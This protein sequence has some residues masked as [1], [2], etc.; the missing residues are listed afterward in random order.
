MPAISSPRW[1]LFKSSL[2][3]LALNLTNYIDY[4]S[5]KSEMM[6]VVHHSSVPMRS[7]GDGSSSCVRSLASH[8]ARKLHLIARYEKL[9]QLLSEKQEYDPVHVNDFAPLKPQLC[10]IYI[11]ELALPFNC[12]LYSYSYGNNLGTLWFIWKVPSDKSTHQT[13]ILMEEIEKYFILVK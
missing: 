3:Q 4:L 1:G 6:D 13:K 11:K 12:E 10:Y 2:E 8:G 5:G 7:P 9:E